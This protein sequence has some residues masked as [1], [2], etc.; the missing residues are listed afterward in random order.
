M[1]RLNEFFFLDCL[2]NNEGILEHLTDSL[3]IS[4]HDTNNPH[5]QEITHQRPLATK[6]TYE[7]ITVKIKIDTTNEHQNHYDK[8]EL[9]RPCGSRLVTIN[10]D[11]RPSKTYRANKPRTIS[12]SSHSSENSFDRNR[13]VGNM[14][15]ESGVGGGS[16]PSNTTNYFRSLEF[17]KNC[18]SCC[19]FC[20][21]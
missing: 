2:K 8:S 1:Q 17:A 16:A 5:P 20:Q 9:T 15:H 12:N 18:D 19:L 10:D 7:N 6:K 3:S 14:S 4:D 21:K 13:L 11:Q